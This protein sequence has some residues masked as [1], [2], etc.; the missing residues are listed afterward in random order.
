LV[1]SKLH[2]VVVVGLQWGD[3]G[4]GKIVDLL[5]TEADAVVRFQGGNNAGHTLVVDGEQTVLHL[6]PSGALHSGTTCVIGGG[7]VVDPGV[8]V[9]ELDQLRARGY[10]TEPGRLLV[11]QES[12]LIL[13]YH[14]AIDQARERRRGKGKIGTT[15]RGIGPA[16]EDKA[17]R[18]GLRMVDLCDE[19]YFRARLRETVEEKNAYLVG[20]LGEAVLQ[21]D[22]MVGE[23]VEYGKRLADHVT[24]TSHYLRDALTAG[25]KVLFEGAQGVLL[26]VD[27]GTYPFV[28]SSNTGAGAVASGAGIAPKLI[29]KVVGISKAYTTRV[30]GGPFPTELHDAVGERLRSEGGEYGATTGRP[31]RCGWFDAAVLRK[32]VCT[33]GVD[34]LALTKLDVLTGIDPIKM[35]VGYRLDGREIDDVPAS[36]AALERAEPIYEE[37]EGWHEDVT[38]ARSLGELPKA[39]RRYIERLVELVGVPV[40]IVSVGPGRDQTI[41]LVEPFD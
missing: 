35:C 9:A 15:G 17:G 12:H 38:G 34:Y 2:S 23:L 39:A 33:S 22:A 37:H 10:L 18:I 11:S 25:R 24:D 30:G 6:I 21:Y 26:D 14:K 5:S 27:L 13:P 3:E 19:A 31:R 4:K 7:V 28:T 8:L 16:Y 1:P 36:A 32:S 20:M 40:G 41:T 29:G